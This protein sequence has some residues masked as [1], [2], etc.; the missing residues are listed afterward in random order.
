M[1]NA[2]VKVGWEKG[3]KELSVVCIKMVVHG[4]GRDES[5]ERGSVH[6]ED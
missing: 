3:E 6:D 5:T 2:R 1:S 4:N